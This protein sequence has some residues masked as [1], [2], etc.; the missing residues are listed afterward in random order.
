MSLWISL[1]Q[2]HSH[3]VEVN[4]SQVTDVEAALTILRAL[5]RLVL[6][7]CPEVLVMQREDEG[8]IYVPPE[9][10]HA[11]RDKNLLT[12]WAEGS[13]VR[14]RIMPDEEDFYSAASHETYRARLR[15]LRAKLLAK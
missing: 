2:K 5:H 13:R 1:F 8:I 11:K 10:Q 6:E 3:A 15:V 9:R 14:M 12:V 4:L 7:C